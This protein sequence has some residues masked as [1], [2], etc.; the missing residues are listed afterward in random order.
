MKIGSRRVS[1]TNKTIL[2]QTFFVWVGR[3]H[4]MPT[5]TTLLWRNLC[6]LKNLQDHLPFS[7]KKCY[8]L[9]KA[10]CFTVD[11]DDDANISVNSQKGRCLP[12]FWGAYFTMLEILGYKLMWMN[13]NESE[14]YKY[15]FLKTVHEQNRMMNFCRKEK[16]KACD[17]TKIKVSHITLMPV[18]QIKYYRIR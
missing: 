8:F 17:Y 3:F 6:F 4:C 14:N 15:P 16:P 12:F 9:I 1:S 13:T 5:V 7:N 10:C 11:R 18:G 2:K